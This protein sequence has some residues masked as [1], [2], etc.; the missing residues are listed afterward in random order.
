MILTTILAFS[1]TNTY[2]AGADS[3]SVPSRL[4]PIVTIVRTNTGELAVLQ[5]PDNGRPDR[6]FREK[7]ISIFE[8]MAPAEPAYGDSAFARNESRWVYAFIHA[9]RMRAK[10]AGIEGRNILIALE[11]NNWIPEKQKKR[12]LIQ[13]L[14]NEF[15]NRLE[16]RL[17]KA[18]ITNVRIA[19][20]MANELFDDIILKKSESN[21]ADSDIFVLATKDTL[22]LEAFSALWKKAV[23]AGIDISRIEDED[24]DILNYIPVSEM[25]ALMLK[26]RP[27]PI[28]REGLEA[29]R[30]SHPRIGIDEAPVEEKG[31]LILVPDKIEKKSDEVDDAYRAQIETL[32]GV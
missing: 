15:T 3:L 16:F 24:W 2:T 23:L 26:L 25:M 10:E 8:A 17:R 32:R 6:N 12:N 4:D 22:F 13:P 30:D 14:I 7:A 20:G 29:I 1:I 19:S 11:T 28:D 18:G 31:V 27:Y 9:I 21:V 5:N